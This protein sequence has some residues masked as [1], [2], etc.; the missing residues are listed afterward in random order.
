MDTLA[1][2][3]VGVPIMTHF[4]SFWEGNSITTLGAVNAVSSII[5]SVDNVEKLY[6][7]SIEIIFFL[8]LLTL[9]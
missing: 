7:I 3:Y 6:L 2:T 9:L 8:T 5:G 1:G 4:S